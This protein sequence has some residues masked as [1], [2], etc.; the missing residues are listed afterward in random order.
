[1]AR[2]VD[3]RIR[4][5]HARGPA[6]DGFCCARVHARPLRGRGVRLAAPVAERWPGAT[7]EALVRK[8]MLL[9]EGIGHPGLVL[10][11]ED[12]HPA[13]A[14]SQQPTATVLVNVKRGWT[15]GNAILARSCALGRADWTEVVL[16][17]WVRPADEAVA[18]QPVV[19][20]KIE[21]LARLGL[22]VAKVV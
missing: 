20:N 7:N 12:L 6:A 18:G 5:A 3:R 16:E 11:G 22:V 17:R 1:P 8:R 4:G 13:A 14:V 9:D 19:A 21:R 2:R 10:A 15:E